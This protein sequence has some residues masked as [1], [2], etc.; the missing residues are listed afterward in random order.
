MTLMG[1]PVSLA[2]C[3]LICLVG[4]G[5]DEKAFFN[6]SNCLAL[7]VVLGPRLF[8]P[9]PPSPLPPPAPPSGLLFSV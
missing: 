3:S 6:I 8:D 5:V 9:A 7:M 2:N 1:N 4:L